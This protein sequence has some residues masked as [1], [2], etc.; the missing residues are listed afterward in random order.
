MARFLL[1]RGANPMAADLLGITLPWLAATSR[2][3][4]ASEEG[5]DLTWV[6]QRL[7]GLPVIDPAEVRQRRAAGRWPP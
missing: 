4:P 5:R 7:A 2:V 3:N 6:C 1:E